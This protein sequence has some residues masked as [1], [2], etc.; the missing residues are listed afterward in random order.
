MGKKED[1]MSERVCKICKK[2]SDL[3]KLEFEA[4]GETEAYTLMVCGTCWDVI[5]NIA[6]RA[7][8]QKINLLA[9]AVASDQQRIKDLEAKVESL[10]RVIKQIC[11]GRE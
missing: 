8:D 6:K 10:G 9:I 1:E 11:D 3:F 7:V 4:D 5:A 2:T